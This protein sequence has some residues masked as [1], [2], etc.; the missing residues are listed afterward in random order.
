MKGSKERVRRLLNGEKPDRAILC[1]FISNDAIYRHFNGGVNVKDN[2]KLEALR[3]IG[4]IMDCSR[5]Y[6]FAPN[7]ESVSVVNGHKVEVKRWTTWTD[8]K[9]YASAEEYAGTK[10]EY[11][12]DVRARMDNITLA[13]DCPDLLKA[14][15]FANAIGN[16]FFYVPSVGS[17]N[18]MTIYAEIGLEQFSYYLADCEDVIIEQ[19]RLYTDFYC[20]IPDLLPPDWPFEM[21][22]IGDDIAYKSGLMLSPDWMRKNFFPLLSRI[23]DAWHKCGFKVQF[24]SDGDLNLIMDDLVAAG[25]DALNP[26]EVAANMDIADLHHRYPHLILVGGID[27]SWLLPHGKPAE[28]RDA[29]EKAI[30]DS[31]GKIMIGS[32]SELGNE[33]PL[34]NFLAMR[35]TTLNYKY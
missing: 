28:V 17:V 23:I 30:E 10:R 9:V 25:I 1:D 34:E 32:S 21:I 8:H 2:D 27:C 29:V 31:E 13:K 5:F 24:H 16:D 22:F 4:E 20:R 18:L 7:S 19:M 6:Q 14:T 35:D 12:K 15:E 26:I 11:I 33:I 3:L